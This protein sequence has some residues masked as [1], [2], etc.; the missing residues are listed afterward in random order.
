MP[1]H[2]TPNGLAPNH[3]ILW[4]LV[5]TKLTVASVY[6]RTV[7]LGRRFVRFGARVRSIRGA[8]SFTSGRK[9]V[10]FG[11]LIPA[12]AYSHKAVPNP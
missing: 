1:G 7:R 2:K 4:H 10:Q 11:A 9:F 5:Y 6:W 3:N 12:N 8:G